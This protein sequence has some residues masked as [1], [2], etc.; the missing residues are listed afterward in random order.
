MPWAMVQERQEK[1]RGRHL[2]SDNFAATAVLGAMLVNSR[3]RPEPDAQ[4]L[5][6]ES[7]A[8]HIATSRACQF[9]LAPS[10]TR[11]HSEHCTAL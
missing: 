11:V 1:P 9:S 8:V 5:A 7:G 4:L 10:L 3:Y 2:P 6:V